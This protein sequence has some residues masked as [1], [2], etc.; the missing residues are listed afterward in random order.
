MGGSLAGLGQTIQ[1]PQGEK[2][3]LESG[4]EGWPGAVPCVWEGNVPHLH[5]CQVESFSVIGEVLE[6]L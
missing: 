3:P 6:S 2:C 5:F 1:Y 4:K